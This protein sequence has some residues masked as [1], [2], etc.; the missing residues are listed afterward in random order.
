MEDLPK[1]SKLKMPLLGLVIFLLGAV[2]GVGG[3][4]FYATKVMIPEYK[5]QMVSEVFGEGGEWGDFFESVGSEGEPTN[6]FEGAEEGSEG[7]V[8][9]FDVIE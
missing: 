6:P 1:T 5:A 2:V 7:Y 4:Y 9:P 3:F 8:N